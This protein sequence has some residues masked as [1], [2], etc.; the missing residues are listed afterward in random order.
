MSD[1]QAVI[2]QVGDDAH[3]RVSF[4]DRF[5]SLI[6][7]DSVFFHIS[8]PQGGDIDY[9]YLVDAELH[10]E[11]LGKFYVVVDLTIPGTWKY[12]FWSTGSGKGSDSGSFT[13]QPSN[14]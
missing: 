3:C 9:E 12:R 7:P 4:T 13:V 10:R 11:S 8:D 14:S 2:F 5:G 1:I 6:D